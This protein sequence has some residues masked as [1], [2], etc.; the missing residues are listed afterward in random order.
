MEKL[1]GKITHY[2][3][4]NDNNG[5]SIA[6]IRTEED[7]HIIVGYFPLLN[8]D[9]DYEFTGEWV[10]HNT[11]GLQFKIESYKKL[12]IQNRKG[13]I[14]YLS[15]P[16]FYGIGPV[17]A[18]K[19]VDQF[20]LDAVSKILDDKSILKEI[21]LS[22]V[23]IEKFYQQLKEHQLNEHILVQLYGYDLT[24]RLAMKLLKK[25]EYQ[26]L[27]KLEENPYRLIEEVEGIGFIKADE[28][29]SKLGIEK[30]DPI[31]IR[32]A[33]YYVLNNIS[34]Q[35]GDIYL[36]KETLEELTNR[37]V[38]GNFYNDELVLLMEKEGTLIIE[39]DRYYLHNAYYQEIE[40]AEDIKRLN[41]TID[42][43]MDYVEMLLNNTELKRNI[44]YTKTQKE[45]ILTSLV[46][47]VSIITG[48]PGTGKTTIID[49]LLETY[50]TYYRLSNDYD[51]ESKIALMAPTGRAAKRMSEILDFNAKTIHRTL[52]YNYEGY[53]IYDRDNKMPYDLIII[54]EASMIDL[55]LANKLFQAIKSSAQVVIVGDVD[56]LPSVGAGQV[57]AD[58]INSN[59]IPTV[60]LN[61][62]HRQ[63]KDSE[64]VT[65]ASKVNEQILSY[66]DLSSS[67]DVFLYSEFGV[68]NIQKTILEQ[69]AGA[70][71]NGYSIIEDIQ[72]LAPMYKGDLGIDRL[73]FLIQKTFNKNP[74]DF[75]NYGDKT[76]STGDK[77]IQLQNDPERMVMNGDIGVIKDIR[78]TTEDD[79]YLVVDFDGNEVTYLKSDL[80]LLNLAYAL[81]IHKAQGSEYQVVIIPMVKSFMHMLKKELIYTAITRAKKY[82]IIL[83]D[84]KLLIY[85]ANHLAEKRK[86]TLK[87][88]LANEEIEEELSPYDFM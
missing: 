14:S 88:R 8:K 5:Y 17:T 9:T 87:L 49:G 71:K 20:G 12:E 43:D 68:T 51:I 19:I 16:L 15:S 64:I 79:Q 82:L 24:A 54:D 61:E 31:R 37:V 18:E 78:Y 72:V 34:Y 56:Q 11:Y 81:S 28:I 70:V 35:S 40:V 32:A 58:L 57:L 13:V 80:D 77:V 26:T 62:I 22:N 39:E 38:G 69:M 47:K 7:T 85:A 29:A 48:G 73:N 60:V 67:S 55:V 21:G 41:K 36:D 6:K 4:H 86:T 46:N 23:R 10:T 44:E 76:F 27:E 59:V 84:M 52:G 30:D 53:F 42:V 75:I 45:A 1:I 50:K 3:F 65:L 66:D 33:I 83:G 25:Y 63:A 2:L 74:K